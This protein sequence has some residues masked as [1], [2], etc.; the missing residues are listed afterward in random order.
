MWVTTVGE[1]Q[2]RGWPTQCRSLRI[3]T[4]AA[5]RL[6]S[7][8]FHAATHSPGLKQRSEK[9][10][11]TGLRRSKRLSAGS[12]KTTSHSYDLAV[13]DLSKHAGFGA[14]ANV[15]PAPIHAEVDGSLKIMARYTPNVSGEP[16]K[17]S[18][19]RAELHKGRG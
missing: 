4:L 6:H 5:D 15:L 7:P 16:L 14:C 17:D 1:W 10:L 12:P 3:F 2:S 8:C 9:A 13:V 18:V 11:P 19:M